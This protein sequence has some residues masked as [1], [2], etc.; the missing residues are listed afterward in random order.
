MESLIGSKPIKGGDVLFR[1]NV[2]APSGS[3]LDLED[4]IILFDAKTRASASS[5]SFTIAALSTTNGSLTKSS[6][7]ASLQVVEGKITGSSSLVPSFPKGAV[8]VDFGLTVV[9]VSGITF[10]IREESYKFTLVDYV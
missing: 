6:N 2:T 3:P 7:T 9:T 8:E 10:K 4:C 1:I 5:K